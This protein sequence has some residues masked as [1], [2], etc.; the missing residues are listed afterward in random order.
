MYKF[1]AIDLDGTLL[2]SYGEVSKEN[3]EAIKK[4]I[5]NGVEVVLSSGRVSTSVKNIAYETGADNYLIAGNGASIY[6]IKN[7]EMI[8]DKYMEKEKILKICEICEKNSIYYN[9]YTENSI[10]AKNLNHN[11]LFY[12]YENLKKPDGKKTSINIVPN[13]YQYI[14][15]LDENKFL[16]ITI[17]DES[18]IVFKSIINKLRKIKGIDVLDVAHMSRKVI[19]AGTEDVNIAYFYTEIT[20]KN[21]NK[22]SAIEYL[23][24]KLNIKQEEVVAIGD[25]VNDKEMIENAG[26]GVVMG[27]SAPYIK[28]MGD[29]VVSDN[30]SNGV[31]EAF[32]KHIL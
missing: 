15:E 23:I 26:L 7:N 8:Y 13:L 18:Q 4:A 31:A 14:K 10:L 3:K 32:N 9:V 25:N 30:N 17:C 20:N 1:V 19:K 22:W 29:V 16:K 27:N 11:V 5:E 2:N 21:V 12:H 24:K 28:E 6:D